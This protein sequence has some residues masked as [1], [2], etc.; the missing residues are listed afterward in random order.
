VHACACAAAFGWRWIPPS[1]IR[2]VVEWS[3][4]SAGGSGREHGASRAVF[5]YIYKKLAFFQEEEKPLK[6]TE[7]YSKWNPF[8][9][10][11]AN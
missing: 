1:L 8:S 5:F 4:R 6:L 9:Y 2:S 10:R 11:N 7:E 3:E